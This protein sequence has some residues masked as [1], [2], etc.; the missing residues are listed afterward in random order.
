MLYDEFVLLAATWMWT[1]RDL[2]E[3][4]LSQRCVCVDKQC[5]YI[6]MVCEMTAGVVVLT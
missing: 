6:V 2:E 4:D 5:I 3:A 1:Q